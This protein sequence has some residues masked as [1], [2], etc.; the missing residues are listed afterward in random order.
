MKKNW[1]IWKRSLAASLC[2]LFC[3]IVLMAILAIARALV[4]TTNVSASSNIS[5]SLIMIPAVNY[6]SVNY[7]TEVAA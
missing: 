6:T 1:I 5:S 2:E 4:D 3:P 7:T